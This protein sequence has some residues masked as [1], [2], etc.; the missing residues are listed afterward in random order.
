MKPTKGLCNKKFLDS[1]GYEHRSVTDRLHLHTLAH[2]NPET[3]SCTTP[4][5]WRVNEQ[6]Q[7]L[8]KALADHLHLASQKQARRL[9][10]SG[11]C[12]VNGRIR[13]FA[14]ADLR[15]GD[16]IEVFSP[17]PSHAQ[18]P[19][20]ILYED[21]WLLVI[22]KPAGLLVEQQTIDA[23]VGKSTVLVHR[24]DKETSGLLLL[25]KNEEA[26]AALKRMFRERTIR[27][28][29]LAIVDGKV[30]RQQGVASWPLKFKKRV[31]REVYWDVDAK[32]KEAVTEFTR[33]RVGKSATLLELSPKT[34]RTHQLRI[35]MARL[36]HP[37]L[38]DYQYADRFRTHL[39]PERCLLHAWKLEFVHPFD[40]QVRKWE[41]PLPDD[42]R[43]VLAM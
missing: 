31:D 14:S 5:R 21:A 2:P 41:A 8:P 1:A 24:L 40:G 25:A 42:M 39:R 19:C 33:L 17:G 36:G 11:R 15:Q 10:E 4:K 16:W 28:K 38:G 23:A 22:D 30:E 20:S 29:Y 13:T 34:G 32:G 12:S 43:D 9:I 7:R 37:I 3:S 26:A 35:H 18:R 27:K 6:A